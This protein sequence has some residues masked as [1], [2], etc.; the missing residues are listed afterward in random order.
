MWRGHLAANYEKTAIIFKINLIFD[1]CVNLFY[2]YEKTFTMSRS[3]GKYLIN[4]LI[5]IQIFLI[6]RCEKYRVDVH[7]HN[8]TSCYSCYA[9]EYFSLKIFVKF[10]L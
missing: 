10:V 4:R 9:I 5:N 2:F 8:R 6:Q 7:E 3:F 1:N